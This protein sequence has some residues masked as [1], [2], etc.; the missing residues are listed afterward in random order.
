M[1]PFIPMLIGAAGGALMNRKDPLKGALLGGGLGAAGGGL[2]NGAQ[3]MFGAVPDIAM[4]VEP[5]KALATNA[6]NVTSVLGAP[7][8][9]GIGGAAGQTMAPIVER[10]TQAAAGSWSP[11]MFERMGMSKAVDRA[12]GLLNSAEKFTK[13]VGTAM[14]AAQMMRPQEEPMPMP[15]IP[16]RAPVAS[17]AFSQIAQNRNNLQAQRMEMENA[18]KNRRYGLINSM[19]G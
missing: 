13:P 10:G 6:A 12:G 7:A 5:A 15:N 2:L 4:G 3:G 1:F 18:R 11:G 8:T 14:Q 16:Q 9:P 19:M 17:P